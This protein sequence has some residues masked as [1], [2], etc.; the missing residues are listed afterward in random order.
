MKNE[1]RLKYK[2]R[3]QRDNKY[4]PTTTCN[5][6]ALAMA[7]SCLGVEVSEDDLYLKANSKRYQRYALKIGNWIDK[8]IKR[9]KLNQVWK[10]LEKLADEALGGKEKATFKSNWLTM[11]DIISR[12]NI[13]QPVLISGSFTHGGHIVCVVG[14][15]SI[16]LI[17]ADPW[18]DWNQKYKDHDGDG[19]LYLYDKLRPVLKGK[20]GKYRALV[21]RK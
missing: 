4:S 11:S 14:H 9:R 3:S 2:Y 21:L 7:L 12:I 18:G 15:N 19:V 5:V 20:N 13:G 1:K 10:I 17:C 16:G 8:F 6:T